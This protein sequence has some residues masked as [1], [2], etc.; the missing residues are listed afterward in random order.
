M[1]MTKSYIHGVNEKTPHTNR[2]SKHNSLNSSFI[3]S[4]LT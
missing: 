1:R 2:D 4:V 3:N